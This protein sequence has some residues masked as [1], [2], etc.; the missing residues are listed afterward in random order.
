MVGILAVV[1]LLFAGTLV[2]QER[3][4]VGRLSTGVIV[5]TTITNDVPG[6]LAP[7]SGFKIWETARPIFGPTIE[8]RVWRRV[9]IEGDVLYRPVSPHYSGSYVGGGA[10]PGSS[11]AASGNGMVV[12]ATGTALRMP[13]MWEFPLLVKR[14]F[15]F[16][17][18]WLFVGAGPSFRKTTFAFET[19][20]V[21]GVATVGMD[22]PFWRVHISP[23][24]R[25]TRWIP[26]SSP[27]DDLRRSQA[28]I[29][30]GVSF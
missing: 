6:G 19:S 27:L 22:I 15:A 20:H 18:G 25:Y 16:R 14:R 7:P 4:I 23:T 12:P 8:F 1:V 26:G 5:G 24:V 2:A 10:V 11:G 28:S 21:G 17:G 3:S 29:L 13:V 30:L 9:A